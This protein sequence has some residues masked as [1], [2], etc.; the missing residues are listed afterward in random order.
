M[1]QVR[2]AD[3]SGGRLPKSRF[4]MNFAD[5][6]PPL[7]TRAALVEYDRPKAGHDVWLVMAQLM[8]IRFQVLLM[9]IWPPI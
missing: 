8:T 1:A 4:A 5:L 3:V 9:A 2:R 7:S 6:H